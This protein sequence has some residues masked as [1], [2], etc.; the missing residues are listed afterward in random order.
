MDHALAVH[1]VDTIGNLHSPAVNFRQGVVTLANVV[2]KTRRAK[3][4]HHMEARR[5]NTGAVQADNIGM[6]DIGERLQ[7]RLKLF[8]LGG[9][10]K[11]DC[12]Q[13]ALVFGTENLAKGPAAERIE[14]L[15][16]RQA[17]A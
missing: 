16:R 17:Q 15:P 5:R 7:F 4:H 1:K 9:A 6:R 14:Q 10:H 11:L 2:E 3:L 8:F 13:L 12:N